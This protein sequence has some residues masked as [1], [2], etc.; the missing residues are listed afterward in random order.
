[1]TT[2]RLSRHGCTSL[3]RVCT[4]V[5]GRGL[6]VGSFLPPISRLPDGS[7]SP[8]PMGWAE[9]CSPISTLEAKQENLTVLHMARTWPSGK[10]CLHGMEASAS[11]WVP[12]LGARFGMRT[13]SLGG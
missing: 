9:L 13:P 4:T 2:L 10:R 7:Q 8:A 6:V 12:A 5:N 11:I 3:L 1:M